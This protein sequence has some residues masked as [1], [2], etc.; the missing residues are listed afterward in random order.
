M[1]ALEFDEEIHDKVYSSE[2]DIDFPDLSDNNQHVN[3]N[4]CNNCHD[5]NLNT[6]TS[7][8]VIELLKEVTANNLHEKIIQLAVSNTASSSFSKNSEKLKNDFE[9]EYIAPYSLSEINNRL[10]KPII[11]T[12]DS[13][14]D[15][16]KNKIE[17]LKNE[18]KSIKLNQIICDHR[19]TQIETGNNKGKTVAEENTLAKPINLD[20]RQAK[21]AA[22]SIHLEDIPNNPLYAQLHAYLSQKQSNTFAS[23][24]KDDVHDIKSYEKVEKREM[25]FLLEISDIQRKEEPW[26]I[27]QWYLLNGLYLPGYNTSENVYSF[28]KMIIKQIIY[29]EDWGISSMTERQF[30]LNKVSMKFTYWE[31]IQAFNKVLYYNNE[32]HKH[33]WF[34]K[35]IRDYKSIPHKGIIGDTLVRHMT[36]KFSNQ[37]EDDQNE[38]INNYLERV[39]KNLLHNI[40][41]NAKSDS[42]MSS[43][44]SDDTYEAQPY[45]SEGHVSEDTLK[46]AEDFLLKLK[47]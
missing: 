45:E 18:I 26:K 27:F 37:E 20:P 1:K 31:Y 14:F 41:K 43:E 36:R 28:S 4:A 2:E 3:M 13:S 46:K 7:N 12:R 29:I 10:N 33:T 8:N 32:R 22:S 30:N 25:I 34:I 35:T 39:K 15:D 38:M 42:S 21:E 11:S 6:I 19:I 40:E 47:K 5:L 17:S 44:T 23:I 16:L 24:A 9:F